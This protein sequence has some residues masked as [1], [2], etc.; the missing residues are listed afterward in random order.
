MQRF[1]R[2][3]GLLILLAASA[4]PCWAKRN[5]LRRS[6]LPKHVDPEGDDISPLATIEDPLEAIDDMET[7]QRPPHVLPNERDDAGALL[8]GDLGALL[9]ANPDDMK[10]CLFV[11]QYAEPYMVGDTIREHTMT[12]HNGSNSSNTNTTELP[13]LFRQGAIWDDSPTSDDVP[14]AVEVF[15]HLQ[16]VTGLVQVIPHGP[17]TRWTSKAKVPIGGFLCMTPNKATPSAPVLHAAPTP[18]IPTSLDEAGTSLDPVDDGYEVFVGTTRLKFD[19]KAKADE[20]CINYTKKIASDLGTTIWDASSLGEV[21]PDKN[22]NVSSF[23]AL[24]GQRPAPEGWTKGRKKLLVV[25][26]D[27][28]RGDRT[29]APY[30]QQ[31]DNP[32]GLYRTKIFPAVNK[33][34]EEMSYGQ[35]GLD[36]TIVPDVIRYNRDRNRYS[37][38][39]MPFPALYEA[40][41][42]SLEGQRSDYK[43]ADYDL[44]FVIAPQVKPTGTKGVAWVGMKGAMC[45]GCEKISDNFKIMVAVH[46]LGHNLGLLHASSTSLEYGNPFDW[47]GNY[48]DVVGLHYG[49]GYVRSLGWLPEDT[50]YKVVDSDVRGLSTLVVIHPHDDSQKPKP[51]QIAGVQISLSADP[52]DIYISYRASP[53]GKRSGIFVTLQDKDEANSELVDGGC[54]TPSQQDAALRTGWFYMDPSH[55]IALKVVDMTED[56][57]KVLIFEAKS[58]DVPRIYAQKSFTDGE[59]KCPVTCQDADWLMTRYE[60]GDLKSSGYC[61]GGSITMSGNKY[62]IGMDLCP[63]TCG[64]CKTKMTD[65]PLMVSGGCQDKNMKISG[66]NCRQ[67]AAAGWCGYETKGGSSIGKDLCP[68][69]CGMCPKTVVPNNSPLYLP[70]PTRT[71]GFV[72]GNDA[73]ATATTTTT[74]APASTTSEDDEDDDAGTEDDNDDD[75]DDEADE[76]DEN[77][78]DDGECRDDAHWKDKDADGCVEYAKVINDGTWTKKQACNYNKGAAKMHCRKT[79][80]SCEPSADTCADT[81]CISIFKKHLGR[82]EQCSDWG[83]FCTGKTASWFKAECPLTC[84]VCTPKLEVAEAEAKIASNSTCKDEACVTAWKTPGKCPACWELG[85]TFC[86]EKVFASACPKTCNLCDAEAKPLETCKDVFSSY[87]C[88]R[89]RSYGWCTREDTRKA[90]RKQCPVACGVC[91]PDADDGEN[92]TAIASKDEKK[93]KEAKA[94]ERTHSPMKYFLGAVFLVVLILLLYWLH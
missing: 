90:V 40:A 36:V 39:K 93:K 27:W 79:C 52:R 23:V 3:A 29:L 55:Q 32:I 21:L 6:R 46:E 87:T 64:N 1:I 43:F 8:A 48:P 72:D 12:L 42:E 58:D 57:A 53:Q 45:N 84:G 4:L 14:L 37:S 86:S 34:F 35:F 30:S 10:D 68:A 54:H 9:E 22:P 26:M 65:T 63:Q 73:P 61:Q 74:T 7:R 13:P 47:M 60:C 18:C 82:C 25:V 24:T 17:M 69:T 41:K 88:N 51:G 19:T 20:F 91:D 94:A 78:D 50:V 83:K 62:S 33:H 44:A 76:A 77:D 16:G 67:A 5:R 89:Y 81:S 31:A 80:G 28:K 38:R 75:N 11:H 66:K 56:Y 70:D 92:S 71:V 49:L 2:T 15:A 85:S 59:T